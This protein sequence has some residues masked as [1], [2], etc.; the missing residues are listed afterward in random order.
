MIYIYDRHTLTPW[1]HLHPVR[2]ITR[3][4]E[5]K[6]FI[7]PHIYAPK[8]PPPACCPRLCPEDNLSRHIGRPQTHKWPH[9]PDFFSKGI[10]PGVQAAELSLSGGKVLCVRPCLW[11]E[12]DPT[13][14]LQNDAGIA[15]VGRRLLVHFWRWP[16]AFFV[17]AADWHNHRVRL[18]YLYQVD[19][20]NKH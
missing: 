6:P 16:R 2:P 12:P 18:Q 13:V 19:K 14:P 8:F 10:H 3:S 9:V 11:R 4:L 1:Y 5:I 7:P 20:R 17:W 15:A